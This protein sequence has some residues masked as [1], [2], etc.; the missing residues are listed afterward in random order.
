MHY[1][2]NK[3]EHNQELKKFSW[4]KQSEPNRTGTTKAYHPNKDSKN[5]YKKYKSWKD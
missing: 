3:I 4:Q 2:S 1:L 5:D